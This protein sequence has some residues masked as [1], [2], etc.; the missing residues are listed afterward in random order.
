MGSFVPT[1]VQCI[2]PIFR[3]QD[4]QKEGPKKCGLVHTLGQEG[5]EIEEDMLSELRV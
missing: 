4:V 5:A 1:V 3:P 2:G